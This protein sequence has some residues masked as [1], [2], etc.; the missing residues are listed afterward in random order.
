MAAISALVLIA[1]ASFY[2]ELLVT[3]FDTAHAVVIGL[4]PELIRYGLLF[5][6]ALTVVAGIQTVGVV[7]VLALL[8][9]PAAS[10]SLLAKKLPMVI[11]LSVIF[12]VGSAIIGFYV[13]YYLD[14]ASGATIVL[15]LSAIFGLSFLLSRLR[16]LPH[17]RGRRR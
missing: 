15:T 5:L 17:W 10:A 13:S 1:V 4:S 2:K 11:G 8:V 3:S 6:I 12:A 9:T 7:L 14:V 16:L